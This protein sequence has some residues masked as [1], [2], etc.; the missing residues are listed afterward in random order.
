MKEYKF[1]FIDEAM[2]AEM[3]ELLKGEHKDTLVAWS[4]ECALAAVRGY[5]NGLVKGSLLM[6]TGAC[7]VIG[8]AHLGKKLAQRQAEKKAQKLMDEIQE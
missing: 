6:A 5:R 7:V 2:K 1:M 8:A 4:Y 3:D